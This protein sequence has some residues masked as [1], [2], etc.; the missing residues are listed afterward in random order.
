M[1]NQKFVG[2]YRALQQQVYSN[3]IFSIV[4]I[5]FEDR[6]DI[7]KWRNEQIFHLRQNKILTSKDQDEYFETVIRK[8][9]DQLSPDQI[10]FSFLE[11]NVCVGYGGLVHINWIDRNAEISFILNTIYEQDFFSYYLSVFLEL[12]ER[13]AFIDLNFHKIYSY[14]FDV[15][16][17]LYNILEL[18]G[19]EKDAILKDH[20]FFN[21]QF[22]DVVIHFK[23]NQI[24]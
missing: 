14:A 8:Q 9:F 15:R 4:P 19:Y 24:N 17:H 5:R 22:K 21:G 2:N 3:N 16:P 7:L 6:M 12:I 1:Y 13:V 20:C 11:Q 18:A 10:L 23:L